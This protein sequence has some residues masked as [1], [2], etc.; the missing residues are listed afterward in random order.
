MLETLAE[1]L[2]AFAEKTGR[3]LAITPLVLVL[4]QFTIVLM[5]Y[6]FA[7]GSI[8]LQES[9]SYINA[10][11]FLGGAGYTLLHDDHVRVDVIYEKLSER[12]RALVNCLGCVFLLL[13]F[14]ILLWVTAVPYALDSW[15]VMEGSVETG[16]IPLVYLLKSTMILFA[17]TL[18]LQ[19]FALF[20]RSL[21]KYKDLA[22]NPEAGP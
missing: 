21:V 8:K 3:L 7:S 14:L 6:V 15:S 9:L 19:G 5:V 18:S 10:V 22:I 13:P 11:M 4:I 17:L 20:A 1:R 2:D 12:R 16:G